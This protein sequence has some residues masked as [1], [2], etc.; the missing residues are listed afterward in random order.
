MDYSEFQKYYEAFAGQRY[1]EYMKLPENRLIQLAEN[2]Q[3]DDT[4]QLW[5]AIKEKGT[6]KSIFVLL[7]FVSNLSNDYLA[8]Y[9]ACDALFHLAGINDEEFK[10]MVQYGRNREKEKIDQETAIKRLKKMIAD[11]IN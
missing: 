1:Q 2:H 10:G 8:R 11:L 6:E 7:D 9:H 4:F 3:W 5:K